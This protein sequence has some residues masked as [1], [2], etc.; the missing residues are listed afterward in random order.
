MIAFHP[1][2]E[3]RSDNGSFRHAVS[4]DRIGI[5]CQ[6]IGSR[7]IKSGGGA[8]LLGRVLNTRTGAPKLRVNVPHVVVQ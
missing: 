2:D 3:G 6:K 8:K 1:V 5:A 7:R 4:E